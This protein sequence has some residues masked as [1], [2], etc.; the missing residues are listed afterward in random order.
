M[1][2]QIYGQFGIYN[3]YVV[4]VEA[5]PPFKAWYTGMEYVS[6]SQTLTVVCISHVS[7]GGKEKAP[8]IESDANWTEFQRRLLISKRK[9]KTVFASIDIDILVPYKRCLHARVCI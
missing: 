8:V 4:G 6:L 5:G 7:S 9:D 2:N 1:V 3:E